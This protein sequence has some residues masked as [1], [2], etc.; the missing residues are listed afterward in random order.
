MEFEV[1][2][3]ENSSRA[4]LAPDVLPEV[5]DDAKRTDSH[6][7]VSTRNALSPTDDPMAD[8]SVNAHWYVLRTTY[9]REQKACDYLTSQNVKIFYPTIVTIKEIRG[10]RKSV[11]ESRLPNLLFAYGT[12]RRLTPLVQRNPEAPY[13]RFYCRYYRESGML[14]R[15]PIMV[16][17]RQ[18]DSLMRICAVEDKHAELFSETIHKFEKGKKVRIVEGAFCGVEGTVARFRGEQRV[19]VIIGG[20]LTAVTAYIPS[21]FL[22]VIES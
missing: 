15:Q 22:E 18:M 16:P 19:G 4:G 10:K 5:R 14:R 21:A 7:G 13:L 6:T 12:E 1:T 9:G 3:T 20:I 11:R 8:T 17:Q 2:D